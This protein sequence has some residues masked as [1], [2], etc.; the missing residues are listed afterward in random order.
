MAQEGHWAIVPKNRELTTR[1]QPGRL[2]PYSILP[3]AGSKEF[4]YPIMAGADSLVPLGMRA[5]ASGGSKALRRG[6]LL[7]KR[8]IK[9]VP[10]VIAGLIILFQFFKADKFTNPE[11][12][13]TERVGL[14][15]EQEQVLGLQS[16]QEVLASS[17]VVQSGP[18]VRQVEEVA[19]KI[20]AQTG[21]A[22]A[23]FNWQVSVVNSPQVNA[24]CLPGG[25]MVVY[26]GILP[27]AQNEAGLATVLGH[28]VAHA[29][30]RHGA[31]RILQNQIVQTAM[32]G[33]SFSMN[34]MDPR[35]RQTVMGLLG[36]GAQFG[37]LLPFG[38]EHEVEADQIGLLYMARAGYDPREA[39]AFW[40][41][42]SESGGSQPPEFM[43]THPSHGTRIQ[44]LKDFMPRAMEEY[45]KTAGQSR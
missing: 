2:I 25:K 36:A 39:I 20:A 21:A 44:R 41:R 42:M 35:Q 18:E 43:S 7:M 33:A 16:Y 4:P 28:E 26:T 38:R 13:K 15:S 34:D 3:M 23:D 40:E 11:T 19:R 24:F 22:A 30:S 6:Y 10:L 1:F 27:I 31:Q 8:G 29:T 14:S 12:G 17:E 37:V 5:A 45:E 9:I 32:I